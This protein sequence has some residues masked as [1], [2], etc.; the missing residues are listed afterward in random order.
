MAVALAVNT[1]PD[2]QSDPQA[3]RWGLL[4][5]T[6]LVAGLVGLP[7]LRGAWDAIKERRL[8]VE[9][10]FVLTLGGAFGVSVQSMWRG[11]GP[12]YFEVVCLLLVVYAFGAALNRAARDRATEALRALSASQR[13]ARLRLG[14]GAV[15]DVA[16]SDLR[17]GDLVEVLPG[18]MVPVDGMLLDGDALVEE[19]ALRGEFLPRTR[20][21]GERVLAGSFVLDAQVLLRVEAPA[22][23]SSLDG[24]VC[25]VG[26]QLVGRSQAEQA[27]DRL[28]RWFVPVVATVAAL[29]FAG[30][31]LVLP[32]PD[33]LFH[34]MAVL[35]VACPCALGFATPLALW[36]AASRLQAIGV[37][38]ARVAEVE[39]LAA[40]DA[41]AFDKT[42]TLSL[43][44]ARVAELRWA[45]GLPYDEAELWGLLTAAERGLSHPYARALSR[46][47][48]AAEP[49][50]GAPEPTGRH[51]GAWRR[52]ALRVLPGMGIQ[53]HLAHADG[54]R[55]ELRIE[56][57]ATPP[58]NAFED[59][60]I[61][62]ELGIL[63]EPGIVVRI[64]GR[65]AGWARLREDFR[66]G[67]STAIEAFE[68]MGM[69]VWLLS[70]DSAAR[71]ALAGI[72]QARGEQS[73]IAKREAIAAWQAS[74]KRVLFVG[75]GINDAAA[76]VAAD[77]AIALHDGSALAR[78]AAGILWDGENLGAIPAALRI[79]RQTMRRVRANFRW[80]IGYNA[81]GMALAAAGVLHPVTAALLMVA[82]SAQVT[83]RAIALLDDAGDRSGAEAPGAPSRER[84]ARHRTMRWSER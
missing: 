42:G 53:A 4:A 82:S 49:T 5:A 43:A 7:L 64:D 54:R 47:N 16:A 57:S 27:A 59:P 2:G 18:E 30:W 62:A 58:S 28:A 72:P 78:A 79:S 34:A 19:S 38:V 83:W 75:D 44:E 48:P 68:Q 69:G 32:W 66:E 50:H 6:L 35:L 76:M 80:A 3:I 12:V 84:I 26:S 31:S 74:G 60:A 63:S 46:G 8:A 21:A 65:Y 20:S 37:R 41:V 1:S 73:A 17:P 56:G 71:T 15:G 52:E 67:R 29:S 39:K 81:V 10:L 13:R 36:T 11:V 33:A 55:H 22:A 24:I 51:S 77:A 14:N 70:G 9:F 61:A 25:E 23:S 45:S 40:V